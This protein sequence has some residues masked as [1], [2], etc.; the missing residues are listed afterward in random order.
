M[1]IQELLGNMNL[2]AATVRGFRGDSAEV[3]NDGSN[4]E[5]A[6]VGR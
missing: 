5:A 3:L 6:V 2:G 4:G 1:D